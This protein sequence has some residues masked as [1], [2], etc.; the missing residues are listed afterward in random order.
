M[1]DDIPQNTWEFFDVKMSGATSVADKLLRLDE[2]EVWAHQHKD[3]E[4]RRL[5]TVYRNE[6]RQGR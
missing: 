4:M 1:N 5:I 6:I 2:L 3:L